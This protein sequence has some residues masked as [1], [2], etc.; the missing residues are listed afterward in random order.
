LLVVALAVVSLAGCRGEPTPPSNEPPPPDPIRI[1]GTERLQWSQVAP[2]AARARQ[3]QYRLYIDSDGRPFAGVQCNDAAGSAGYD[4]S[5]VLPGVPNGTHTLSLSATENGVEGPRSVPLA[6]LVDANRQ[7]TD[8]VLSFSGA[9]TPG[10]VCVENAHCYG[11][12]VLLRVK[13]PIASAVSLA[14]GRLVFLE[15]GRQV[16]MLVGGQLLAD[17]AFQAEPNEQLIAIVPDVQFDSTR[18][19]SLVAIR[20][21]ANGRRSLSIT[22]YR[23]LANR[24]AEGTATVDVAI[25]PQLRDGQ[26]LV[27]MDTSRRIYVADASS[28]QLLRY[29]STGTV[30]WDTGQMSP[31]F[32]A[33]PFDPTAITVD[34]ASGVVWIAGHQDNDRSV[35]ASISSKTQ[36]GLALS[37]PTTDGS[38][39]LNSMAFAAAA[40]DRPARL[41]AVD[42]DGVLRQ[43]RSV[44]S[45]RLADLAPI[46][47][48]AGSVVSVTPGVSGAVIVAYR[49]GDWWS[50]ASLIPSISDPENTGR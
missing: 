38:H 32:T 2:S 43:A 40:K 45:V 11:V 42:D 44:P 46:S 24:L 16:R 28:D 49:D 5:A 17:P 34:R 29:S 47:F 13:T 39:Q 21:G 36:N 23:E 41:F 1:R 50:L 8:D 33:V 4:C 10:S 3:Y 12:R 22:R 35:L 37:L 7:A 19:M 9:E 6:V 30:P 48:A 15:S 27:A 25:D 26:P 20:T 31:V 18:A 14:D